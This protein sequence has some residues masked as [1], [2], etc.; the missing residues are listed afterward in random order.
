MIYDLIIENGSVIDFTTG[1]IGSGTV[2]VAA[3]KIAPPPPQGEKA[4]GIRFLMQQANLFFPVLLM[5]I[6]ISIMTA[7]ISAPRPTSCVH[8]AV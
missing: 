3:G 1:E 4:E 8:Q 2:Y 6:P 5:N 7:Q